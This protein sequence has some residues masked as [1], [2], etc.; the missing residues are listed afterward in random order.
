METT[1]RN[2]ERQHSNGRARRQSPAS[3][4]A[5]GRYTHLKA[6]L[7][8]ILALTLLILFSPVMLLAAFLIKLTSRGPVLYRQTRL[9][10]GG[11]PFVIYKFR[12]MSHDC[13][14]WSGPCWSAAGDP[15]VT[16]VGRFLRSTHLDELPQLWNVL[17]GDMSLVGPRPERPE[18]VPRLAQAIPHYR[19]RLLVRPGVTGLAQVQLPPDLDLATVRRK[20]A[21]DLHY[22]ERLSLWLDVRILFS[23]FFRVL[24][25]PFTVGRWFVPGGTAVERAYEQRAT[26]HVPEQVVQ[27]VD[28]AELSASDLEPAPA[29]A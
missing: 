24:H 21:H 4:P 8:F 10:K 2:P 16:A 20:L 25:L 17:K 9:G 6:I 3:R 27:M 26:G 15:R 7:D 22:V 14:R 29:G 5:L 13:E 28:P 23:T 1:Q 12:S 11:A 18:F 19:D